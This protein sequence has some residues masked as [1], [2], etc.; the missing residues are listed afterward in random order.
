MCSPL[1]Q[2]ISSQSISRHCAGAPH[3]R[4]SATHGQTSH[5]SS[6]SIRVTSSRDYTPSKPS[7]CEEWFALRKAW[8]AFAVCRMD[9]HARFLSAVDERS[10]ETDL[11]AAEICRIFGRDRCPFR[12]LD[13]LAMRFCPVQARSSRTVSEIWPTTFS[14]SALFALPASMN[15]C[16]IGST[17]V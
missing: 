8:L 16:F 15:H 3:S 4:Q 10:L 6:R 11:A 1:S 9:L 5:Q 17:H 13:W 2:P 14:L 7:N 12:R